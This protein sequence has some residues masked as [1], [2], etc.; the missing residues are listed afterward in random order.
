MFCKFD[1]IYDSEGLSVKI[2]LPHKAVTKTIKMEQGE[3]QVHTLSCYL[4]SSDAL[5]RAQLLCLPFQTHTV[6]HPKNDRYMWVWQNMNLFEK[7]VAVV[8]THYGSALSHFHG[9]CVQFMHCKWTCEYDI[10]EL[11]MQRKI[12][13]HNS[14][15]KSCTQLKQLWNSSHCHH[16]SQA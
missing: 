9:L 11:C 8:Q 14:T 3:E 12:R 16:H 7:N 15:S 10:F 1:Y 2:F 13:R 5:R 6:T 4:S